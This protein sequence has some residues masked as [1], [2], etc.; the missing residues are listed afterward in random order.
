VKGSLN[1]ASPRNRAQHLAATIARRLLPLLVCWLVCLLIGQGLALH[2][3]RQL[4]E[5]LSALAARVKAASPPVSKTLSAGDYK[6]QAADLSFAD[7]LIAKDRFSWTD[8]LDR[9]EGTL[10]REV[11]LTRIEPDY[12]ERSL[13]LAGLAE[14]VEALRRYLSSLLHSDSLSAAYLLGQETKKIKDSHGREQAVVVFQIE[15]RK[16][17][18]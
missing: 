1:L 3:R 13:R 10:T 17:F 14:N 2:R 9:L 15:I 6:R 8:L 4:A 18:Q 5:E 11:T 16:A 12:K 7:S